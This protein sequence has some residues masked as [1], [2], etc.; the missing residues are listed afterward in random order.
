MDIQNS[1]STPPNE[2]VDKVT[3]KRSLIGIIFFITIVL[4]FILCLFYV[5]IYYF[6]AP[7]TVGVEATEAD[8]SNLKL[9]YVVYF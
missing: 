5:Y 7:V 8:V 9:R 2:Y 4:I 1:L 3:K 6:Q